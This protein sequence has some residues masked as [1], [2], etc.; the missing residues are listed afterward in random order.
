M[1]FI[2]EVLATTIQW[3]GLGE[4]LAAGLDWLIAKINNWVEPL[5]VLRRDFNTV[6]EVSREYGLDCCPQIY[7]ELQTCEGCGGFSLLTVNC[8]PARLCFGCWSDA[9]VSHLERAA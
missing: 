8:N 7:D 6:R 9:T 3:F 2:A 4:I 1:K 5:E